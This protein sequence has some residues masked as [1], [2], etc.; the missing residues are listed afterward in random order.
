[1]LLDVMTPTDGGFTVIRHLRQT[2][3]SL[4][5]R[6]VLLTASPESILRGVEHDIFGIVH[7]P[8][9]P[10]RLIETVARAIAQ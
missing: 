7:K 3:P 6:V 4:L 10:A 1:M 5:K 9:E 2:N 8:F